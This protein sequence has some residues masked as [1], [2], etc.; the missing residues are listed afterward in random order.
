MIKRI[1]ETTSL[2][3]EAAPAGSGVDVSGADLHGNIMQ[4]VLKISSENY[5]QI[6]KKIVFS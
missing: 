1:P 5:R 4:V 3:K 6:F 2:R